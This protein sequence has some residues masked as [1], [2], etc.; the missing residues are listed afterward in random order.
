M[1]LI[2]VIPNVIARADQSIGF[3]GHVHPFKARTADPIPPYI[4]AAVKTLAEGA[5]SCGK[6][7][8]QCNCHQE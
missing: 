5:E 2:D 6:A 3:A 1:E 4:Q 7:N 8:A